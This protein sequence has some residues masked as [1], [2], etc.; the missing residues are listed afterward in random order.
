M[1]RADYLVKRR[2]HDARLAATLLLLRRAQESCD[3]L[4]AERVYEELETLVPSRDQAGTRLYSRVDATIAA[5]TIR[6]PH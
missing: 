6:D 3:R 4:A 1:D 2:V 5:R